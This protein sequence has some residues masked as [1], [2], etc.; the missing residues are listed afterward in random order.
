M[1]RFLVAAALLLVASAAAGKPVT[2][3][4]A[5]QFKVGVATET[6]VEARLGK[7]MVSTKS[8][9]GTAVLVYYAGKTHVKAATFIPVVGL[10]AGGVQ[11]NTAALTFVLDANGVL[12]S[13]S[14]SQSSLDCSSNIANAG[15]KPN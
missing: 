3:D 11:S 13:S 6:D 10:F 5:A 7:P 1:R 2:A 15:C 14:A 4:D 9:D 12:K 8:S